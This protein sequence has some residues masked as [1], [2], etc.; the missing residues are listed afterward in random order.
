MYSTLKDIFARVFG[1]DT[2]LKMARESGAW[3]RLR[4]IHPLP[5]VLS[6]V[7]CAMG[8]ETRSIATARRMFYKITGYM[9]EESS[10]YN[11]FTRENVAWLQRLF[12][13]ALKY[14][15]SQRRAALAELFQ[16]T[17]VLDMLAIDST[18][19]ALPDGASEDYPS[20]TLGKA[21]Y[22]ITATLS[23]LYQSIRNIK[24]TPAKMHDSKALGKLSKV[25]GLLLLMDRGYASIR[26][27][28]SIDQG[29]GFFVTPL[30]ANWTGRIVKIRSGLG[31][32][33]VGLPLDNLP[34]RGTVDVN[35][36]FLLNRGRRVTFRV[37]CVSGWKR[38]D[39]GRMKMIDIWLL[40]NLSAEQFSAEDV[41]SL[42]R[43]RFE[44]E[45]LFRVLKTVGRLDQLKS[46]KP[47]VFKSFMYATLLGI[48]LSHDICAQMR[49]AQPDKEP[50]PHR[51]TVLV[52][53]SLPDIIRYLDTPQEQPVLA[54]FVRALWR[55]G[56]NPNP[57]RPYTGTLYA[58]EMQA[59]RRRARA[60]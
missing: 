6:L 14:A 20:T 33:N 23:V 52:L 39:D 24:V 3:K 26:R 55:E 16:G 31:Q 45:Q 54:A 41:S 8:D 21:G 43:Y 10:F 42:Y 12:Q 49:R 58:W 15:T 53:N 18:Q 13:H 22:K 5:F 56:V 32:R 44:I 36:S 29:G 19:V 4:D 27:F 57:G 46:R 7:S 38:L 48:V 11:R 2:V 28:F 47:E 50:S 1:N 35:V 51:V 30:K 60:A 17:D 37:V 59:R 40:T 34:F 25:G 9:P